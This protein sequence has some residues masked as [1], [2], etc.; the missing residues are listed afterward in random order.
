MLQYVSVVSVKNIIVKIK[1]YHNRAYIIK[2]CTLRDIFS[3][4]IEKMIIY[5]YEKK[6]K[7]IEY[8]LL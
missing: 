7:E 5:V 4:T 8:L 3:M 6:M 1:K 2:F